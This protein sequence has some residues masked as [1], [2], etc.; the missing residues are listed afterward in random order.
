MIDAV[1]LVVLALATYRVGRFIV[2]DDLIAGWRDRFLGWLMSPAAP[3]LWRFKLEQLLTCPYCITIWVAA[4]A[5]GF[6]GWLIAPWP[7]WAFLPIWLAVAAGALIA[8]YIVDR[9]DTA[10]ASGP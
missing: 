10:V 2:L 5:V 8:W 7:G 6:W 9:D 4:A 3:S 1:D